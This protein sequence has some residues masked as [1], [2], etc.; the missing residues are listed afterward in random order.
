MKFKQHNENELE[1]ENN[2]Q[3]WCYSLIISSEIYSGRLDSQGEI[4]GAIGFIARSAIAFAG[5][6]SCPWKK[7]SCV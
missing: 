1:C 6:S 4:S 3:L 2:L 5:S 7:N